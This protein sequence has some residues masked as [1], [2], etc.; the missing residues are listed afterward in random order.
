MQI[1]G[2]ADWKL[3]LS[4]PHINFP[5][6]CRHLSTLASQLCV[7]LMVEH[8]FVNISTP[9]SVNKT[10]INRVDFDTNTHNLRNKEKRAQLVV[11]DFP[12]NP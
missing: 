10:I 6:F 7:M 8:K 11:A 12:D 5:P 1:S 3:S 2:I 9:S 4:L